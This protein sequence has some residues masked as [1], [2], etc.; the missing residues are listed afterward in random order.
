[1]SVVKPRSIHGV[2]VVAYDSHDE[3]I[4]LTMFK[5]QIFKELHRAHAD[6]F[7][8]NSRAKTIKAF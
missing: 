1:M 5:N 7:F 8:S 2:A 4:G 6:H 3:P